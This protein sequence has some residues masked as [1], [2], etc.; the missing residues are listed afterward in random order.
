MV[1]VMTLSVRGVSNFLGGVLGTT[2][3]VN[4]AAAGSGGGA[5]VGGAEHMHS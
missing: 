5:V 4:D 1:P 3:E 2:S